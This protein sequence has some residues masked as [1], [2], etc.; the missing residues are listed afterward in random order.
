MPALAG[1]FLKIGVMVRGQRKAAHSGV[2]GRGPSGPP[3]EGASDRPPA[4]GHG[5]KACF[6]LYTSDEYFLLS[7]TLLLRRLSAVKTALGLVLVA[8][9][10]TGLHR[11]CDAL[12]GKGP[13]PWGLGPLFPAFGGPLWPRL[14]YRY[15][16]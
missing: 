2:F 4:W 9:A 1:Q 11:L 12:L 13:G 7:F 14:I 5:S 8:A 6:Y 16:K 3:R 15:Y 10:C